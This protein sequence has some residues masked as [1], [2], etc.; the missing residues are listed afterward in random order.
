MQLVGYLDSPFVRRVAI[1]MRYL[2]IAYEHREL[3]IFRNYDEFRHLHPAVKV[4]AL[5]FDDGEVMIDSSLIIN[6]LESQVAGRSLMPKDPARYRSASQ[7]IANALVVMEKIAQ[8]IYETGH[9]PTE[10]QHGPW[11]ERIHQQLEGSVRLMEKAVAA[12]AAAGQAWLS[13]EQPGQADIST[14]VAW[15]FAQHI[16]AV[17]LKPEDF[18]A[19]VAF[20]AQ[21]EQQ[22]EF[23]ACPLSG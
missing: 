10:K 5:V 15:R 1:S 6:Y 23:M 13:G 21:A 9:R 12:N 22:P 20:S 16:D 4:P 2:G 7:Q 14:A 19:L 3:S 11:L 8:L 18:P 17:Q